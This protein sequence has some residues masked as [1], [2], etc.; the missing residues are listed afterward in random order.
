MLL[1]TVTGN[2][3]TT[4]TAYTK[5]PKRSA[6]TETS[7]STKVARPINDAKTTEALSR[8]RTTA[9]QAEVAA[10]TRVAHAVSL[11]ALLPMLGGYAPSHAMQLRAGSGIQQPVT[12]HDA[13]NLKMASPFDGVAKLHAA[14][15]DEPEARFTWLLTLDA[16]AI[17]HLLA[18]CAGA[19]IDATEGKFVDRARIASANRIARAVSLDMRQHWKGG[20]EF[21]DRLG[22]KALLAGLTEACGLAAAENCAKMKRADLAVACAD[23]IPGRGWL[24]AALRTPEV[25]IEASEDERFETFDDMDG[26][27]AGYL[28]YCPANDEGEY[29]IAAE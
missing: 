28:E 22:K 23:R 16:N 20:I 19:L 25:E 1:I 14:L 24:T 2:G 12:T 6:A 9:L 26:E 15:P 3:S 21:F 27:D 11:D 7:D 8:I 13:N 10:N 5:R 4:K 18:A 17:A 29:A